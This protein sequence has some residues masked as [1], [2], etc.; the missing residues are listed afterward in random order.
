TGG[1]ARVPLRAN[2]SKAIQISGR[3]GVPASD[4]S[5]VVLNVTVTN[6]SA[7]SYLTLY[8]AGLDRP[9]AS[10][11]NWTAGK[12]VPN[13]VEVAVGLDGQVIAYNFQGSTDLVIDV[14]GWVG[15]ESNSRG[16]DG[17]FNPLNPSRL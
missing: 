6:T 7:P 4:V 3:G 11:L 10:N 8:P 16:R 15:I 5:A 14:E 17:L 2:S 9:T 1:Y 12:T 13:L